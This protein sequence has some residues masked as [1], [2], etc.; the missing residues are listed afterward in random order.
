LKVSIH[1]QKP[2]LSNQNFAGL[3]MAELLPTHEEAAVDPNVTAAQWANVTDGSSRPSVDDVKTRNR[4]HQKQGGK[5]AVLPKCHSS[6]TTGVLWIA[7]DSQEAS[8]PY[9]Y[10]AGRLP[11][12]RSQTSGFSFSLLAFTGNQSA[13]SRRC[14]I[15]M[16]LPAIITTTYK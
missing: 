15:T 13:K 9:Y 4:L 3:D 1:C 12:L 14:L 7:E 2:L 16:C 10:P 6:G 8:S 11:P 5:D